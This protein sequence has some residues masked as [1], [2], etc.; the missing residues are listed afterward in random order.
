ML[1]ASLRIASHTLRAR[2][3]Y[4][5][6]QDLLPASETNRMRCSGTPRA[7]VGMS[8]GAHFR[9]EGSSNQATNQQVYRNTRA[10]EQRLTGH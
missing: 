1:T 5:I 10:R 4:S 2:R 9:S 3:E 7:H 6:N 8:N